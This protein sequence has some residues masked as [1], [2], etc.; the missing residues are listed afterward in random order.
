MHSQEGYYQGDAQVAAHVKDAYKVSDISIF[1]DG[2]ALALKYPINKAQHEYQFVIPTKAIPNGK[3]LLKVEITNGI[4]NS[5]TTSKEISFFADN[6][7]LQA[8]FVKIDTDTLKVFQGRTL[9]VQFQ[10]NKEIKEA[11]AIAVSKVYQCFKESENSLIY[12]C[13]IPITC[14]E[15]PNEYLL[16]IDIVDR[17]GNT[18]T[19]SNKFQVVAFPFKKQSLTISADK[20]KLEEEMGKSHAI[21]N[22][23]VEEVTKSSPS[24]KLWHGAFYTPIEIKGVTTDFGTIRTTQHRGLYAHKALD[25]VNAPKSVVWAPQD[26]VVALKDRFEYSGNTIVID[27]GYGIISMFFHLDKFANINIG[28]K[29]SRGNPI[30]TLGMT[31][32]ATGYHLH[33]EMR[34]NNIPVDPLQWTKNNF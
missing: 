15:N 7:P 24:K 1:I 32:H 6:V 33:W 3:H 9:H 17:V 26:G 8:A 34:V 10:V 11:T 21:L 20:L 2:K 28:D 16:T 19:L 22:E 4:Y 23:R 31:G 25:V 27:H 5:K 13:F 14:E 30:G 29:I 12:E 18:S